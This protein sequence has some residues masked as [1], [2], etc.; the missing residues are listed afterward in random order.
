MVRQHK[1]RAPSARPPCGR[2]LFSGRLRR[3]KALVAGPEG[4]PPRSRQ[5]FWFWA[6]VMWMMGHT[7]SPLPHL[8]ETSPCGAWRPRWRCGRGAGR[9]R[10]VERVTSPTQGA[11]PV[12]WKARR[13][14]RMFMVFTSIFS[15]PASSGVWWT[16]RLR[17]SSTLPVWQAR[18]SVYRPWASFR[19]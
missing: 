19:W 15:L 17:T 3:M 9:Q 5:Y 14:R 16:K 18:G 8:R 12:P 13:R 7:L 6:F 11:A 1:R 10:V 4:L 2:G